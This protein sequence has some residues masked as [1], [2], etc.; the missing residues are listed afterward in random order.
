VALIALWKSQSITILPNSNQILQRHLLG[1]LEERGFLRPRAY[2]NSIDKDEVSM[3][4]DDVEAI[5]VLFGELVHRKLFSFPDYLTRM[6]SFGQGS[7]SSPKPESGSSM[8]SESPNPAACAFP[9]H[10]E[11]L[12]NLPLWDKISEQLLSQRKIVLH[13]IRARKTTEDA[14]EKGIRTELRR[15]VPIFF[16]GMSHFE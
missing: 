2:A 5:S 12:R 3:T 14:M 11:L 4:R 10:L 8:R 13:G 1:W 9:D 15:V 16:N 7:W 6:T